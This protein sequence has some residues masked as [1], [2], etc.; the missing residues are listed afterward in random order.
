MSDLWGIAYRVTSALP[1]LWRA[2]VEAEV[3]ESVLFV[4]PLALPWVEVVAEVGWSWRHCV[5]AA[6][7]RV[8]SALH[9]GVAKMGGRMV[10][11]L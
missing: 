4:H 8:L 9:I 11:R 1:G 2:A 6:R 10:G 3:E 5:F 7:W